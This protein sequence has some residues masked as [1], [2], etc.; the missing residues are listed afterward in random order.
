MGRRW[1]KLTTHGK[2]VAITSSHGRHVHMLATLGS[3][4]RQSEGMTARN[5]VKLFWGVLIDLIM[6]H[7]LVLGLDY[8]SI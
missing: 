1:D 5:D 7:D 3:V 4:F 2:R 6:L 8:Q